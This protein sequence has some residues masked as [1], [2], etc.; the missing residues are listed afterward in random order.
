MRFLGGSKHTLASPTYFQGVRTQDPSNTPGSTPLPPPRAV[1]RV[2][3]SLKHTD[4]RCWSNGI[5]MVW[6]STV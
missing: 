6:Y 2:V 1:W 3:D 5:T 4:D